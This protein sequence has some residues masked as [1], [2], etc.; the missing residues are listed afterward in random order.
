MA[1]CPATNLSRL[2]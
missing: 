2:Y 1:P